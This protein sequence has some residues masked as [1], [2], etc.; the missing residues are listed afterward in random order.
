MSNRT[1]Q[2]AWGL[3]PAQTIQIDKVTVTN[4]SKTFAELGVTISPQLMRISIQPATTGVFWAM[5]TATTSSP[6]LFNGFSN[7]ICT[8]A[9]L[10]TMEF[11]VASGTIE[12]TIVQEIA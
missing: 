12:M 10:T 4:A 1:S 2:G 8:G 9:S 3:I 7:F 5:G 11:I 6:Q